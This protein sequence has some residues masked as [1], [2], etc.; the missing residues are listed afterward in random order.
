MLK[1]NSRRDKKRKRSIVE[2]YKHVRYQTKKPVGRNVYVLSGLKSLRDMYHDWQSS[3]LK[4][5]CL[6]GREGDVQKTTGIIVNKS[7]FDQLDVVA[8]H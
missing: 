5:N 4:T 7:A 1:V 3:P 2:I 8:R 6:I